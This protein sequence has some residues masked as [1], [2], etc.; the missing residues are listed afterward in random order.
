MQPKRKKIFSSVGKRVQAH[1][2]LQLGFKQKSQA[3]SHNTICGEPGADRAEFNFFEP[4][5]ACLFDSLGFVLLVSSIL[6][7]T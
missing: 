4:I 5:Y 7:D 2:H 1:L 6:S 3:N